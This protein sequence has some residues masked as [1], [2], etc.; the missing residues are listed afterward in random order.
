MPQFAAN[1][2]HQ[3]EMII[4]CH[5]IP[6]PVPISTDDP[7]P[8]SFAAVDCAYDDRMIRI[9]DFDR[10]ERPSARRVLVRRPHRGGLV[11]DSQASV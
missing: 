8:H 10:I 7:D 9:P 4:M 1:N 5:S 3:G 11:V 2:V 6:P